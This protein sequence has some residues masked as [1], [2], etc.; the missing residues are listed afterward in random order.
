MFSRI[1]GQR[2]ALSTAFVIAAAL[3]GCGGGGGG[4]PDV[5]IKPPFITGAVNSVVYDGATDDLLTAGLGKTGLG[6]AAAPPPANATAP[7]SA[8]LRRLAIFNNYRAI[9][10]IAPNGGY[11]VVVR[12]QH[13]RQRRQHAG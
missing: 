3:A 4:S 9:L 1:E 2:I 6:A 10:D 5:A 12:S 13:R 8:E 7:T 11:G